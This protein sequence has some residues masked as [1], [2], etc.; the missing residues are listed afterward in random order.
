MEG[1]LPVLFIFKGTTK[2][3]YDSTPNNHSEYDMEQSLVRDLMPAV[4]S[5]TYT[6]TPPPLLEAYFG[7]DINGSEPNAPFDATDL[8]SV[9]LHEIGHA[10]G[11]SGQL[12]SCV[13]ETG[14][15][16]GPDD[17][18]VNPAHVN[19]AVFGVIAVTV[20]GRHTVCPEC[21]LNPSIPPGLRRLPSATDV[22]ALAVCPEPDWNQI[23]LPRQ[24]FLPGGTSNYTTAGNWVGNQIPGSFDDAFIRHGQQVNLSS[25]RTVRSL[26]LGDGSQLL[27]GAET[28]SATTSI[29]LNGDDDNNTLLEASSNG[30]INTENLIVTGSVVSLNGSGE[31]DVDDQLHLLDASDGTES[32]LTGTGAVTGLNLLKNDGIIAPLNGT[33]SF[34]SIAPGALD[35]DG[36]SETG[37]LDLSDGSL[38]F[39][40]GGM[41]DDFSGVITIGERQRLTSGINWA[42][43]NT[44][45]MILNGGT[46]I[47][48]TAE[49]HQI[50]S[51]ILSFNENSNLDV[52]G[53]GEIEIPTIFSGSANA[54]VRADADLRFKDTLEFTGGDINVAVGGILSL[55]PDATFSGPTTIRGNG[56]FSIGT[57]W[58]V[59]NITSVETGEFNLDGDGF[60]TVN[61]S[62]S[63]SSSNLMN[64]TPP[65]LSMTSPALSIS[66]EAQAAFM[67]TRWSPGPSLE[68]LILIRERLSPPSSRD[69]TSNSLER[70]MQT[71]GP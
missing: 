24:D 44:S 39:G 68:T 6:G 65:A 13:A 58:T 45:R 70:C 50:G 19:G 55:G 18:D 12:S 32:S 61:L 37:T 62:R 69:R 40:S 57:E 23:D 17:F 34:D 4:V 15:L 48:D 60:A 28:L 71:V 31:L 22:L 14:D 26:L 54:I 53:R 49:V 27:L 46:S 52:T 64:W 10:L 66:V 35:L 30:G 1:P 41:V 36:D 25:N 5:A 8:F 56:T 47:L 63:Y 11:L 51:G 9:A 21:L 16:D 67:S 20:N 3:F 33:I 59:N 42:M 7:G 38:S 2:W 29:T 43:D